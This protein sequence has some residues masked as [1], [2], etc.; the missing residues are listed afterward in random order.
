MKDKLYKFKKFEQ[1]EFDYLYETKKDCFKWYVEKIYG[2]WDDEIQKKFFKEEIEKHIEDVK[3]IT[4]KGEAIGV[5]IEYINE[6]DIS[7]IDLFYIDKK[8]QR[9]GLGTAILQEK[10]EENK[11]NGRNTILRVFKDN[12]ARFLYKKIGFEI[13][14]ET[15][16]HYKMIRKLD[17]KEIKL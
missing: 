12:P 15:E 6:E 10:L 9:K 5:F 4:Y 3:I 1:K 16:T 11:N 2:E 7:V 8:Y 17:E 14:E 13:Y